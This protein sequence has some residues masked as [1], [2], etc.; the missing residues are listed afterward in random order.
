MTFSFRRISDGVPSAI[1]IPYS[2]TA[3]LLQSP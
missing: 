2:K 1:L 3:T